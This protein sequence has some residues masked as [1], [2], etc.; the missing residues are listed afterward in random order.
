MINKS[1]STKYSGTLAGAEGG[2]SKDILKET[3]ERRKKIT[4][5]RETIST[6]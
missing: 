5:G 3:I 1:K 2:E 4:K 6:N